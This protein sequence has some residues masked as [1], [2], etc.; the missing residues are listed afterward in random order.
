MFYRVF[1]RINISPIYPTKQATGCAVIPMPYGF[2]SRPLPALVV[3]P[4]AYPYL[5]A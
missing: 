3:F 2:I 4:L 1:P 5:S